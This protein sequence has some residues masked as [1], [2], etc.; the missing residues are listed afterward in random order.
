LSLGLDHD[1][2]ITISPAKPSDSNFFGG[3]LTPAVKFNQEFG[4][5]DIYAKVA[6]PIDYIDEF[7]KSADTTVS[8]ESTLGWDSTFG[9]GLWARLY[10]TL[11]PSSARE[12]YQGLGFDVTYA[13]GPVSIEVSARTYKEFSDGIDITPEFSYNLGAF[14]F[15]VNCEFAGIAADDSSMTISPAL[16][17]TFSF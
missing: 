4:F 1:A 15:Y 17:V 11:A 16:G 2:E 5:G 7:N 10:S 12:L 14:D 8:L 6:A 13:T 3:T 9:L